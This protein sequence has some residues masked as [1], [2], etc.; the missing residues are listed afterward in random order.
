[1][2][3]DFDLWAD[4]P[5]REENASK[6]TTASACSSA[7]G[8]FR[9]EPAG[10]AATTRQKAQPNGRALQFVG[11]SALCQAAGLNFETMFSTGLKLCLARSP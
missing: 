11:A 5:S 10:D 3:S 8:V 2:P 9:T 6:T 4:A 7:A 1:M